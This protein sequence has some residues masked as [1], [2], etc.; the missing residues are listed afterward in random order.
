MSESKCSA[1]SI[2]NKCTTSGHSHCAYAAVEGFNTNNAAA[3]FAARRRPSQASHSA[4]SRPAQPSS[5]AVCTSC[6]ATTFVS[7]ARRNHACSGGHR[8]D[9]ANGASSG[10]SRAQPE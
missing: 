2:R 9:C 4:R 10:A 7:S 1:A 5:S 8:Y 6:T 3:R